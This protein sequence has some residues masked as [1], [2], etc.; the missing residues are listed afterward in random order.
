MLC[1]ASTLTCPRVAC[2]LHLRLKPS[3]PPPSSLPP[4]LPTDNDYTFCKINAN[5]SQ[6]CY[7]YRK[8]S[9]YA[10]AKA[11]C[12]AMGG[13][14]ASWSG[15]EEQLAVETYFDATGVLAASYWIGL[16]RANV[17]NSQYAFADGAEPVGNG[18]VSNV[19]ELDLAACGYGCYFTWLHMGLGLAKHHSDAAA[20]CLGTLPRADPYAHFSW[21]FR[22]AV[23][24]NASLNCTI[25][26]VDFTYD[27]FIGDTSY[28]QQQDQNFYY[29]RVDPP[30]HQQ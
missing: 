2:I 19:G 26:H 21:A 25:A 18:Y 7:F 30:N 11:S 24:L 28:V 5:I 20:R 29:R 9:T 4:G 23:G 3:T 27:Y 1:G 15:D 10:A 12:K 13:Y 8:N 16:E 17:L 14:L 6:S 22:D